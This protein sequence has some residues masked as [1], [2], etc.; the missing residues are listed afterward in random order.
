[1]CNALDRFLCWIGCFIQPFFLLAVRLIWG[2]LLAQAG[3]GKVTDIEP[4]IGFFADLGIP[5]P[6]FSAWL[7][8]ITELV[9][10]VLLVLGLYSRFAA[11]SVVIIMVVAYA[12]AHYEAIANI[13]TDPQQIMNEAPFTFLLASLIIW[14]TGAGVISL[15]W[16]RGK[17]HKRAC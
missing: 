8:G 3:W 16:L 11:A 7:V 17:C 6:E 12:T 13:M 5:W 14:T 4:V 10:G 2:V 15:D 9:A 1:M